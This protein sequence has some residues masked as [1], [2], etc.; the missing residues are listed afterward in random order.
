MLKLIANKGEG[1][2]CIVNKYVDDTTNNEFALKQLK[3]EH[4]KKDDYRYRFNRE[5]SIL[6]ELTG[7]ENIIELVRSGHNVDKERLWYLMPFA[8]LNLY[9]YIKKNNGILMKE[10][11]YN[12]VDQII[13]G[14]KFAHNKNILHRDISPNNVLVF[15]KGES[16]ILK[17]SDFGLG[18]NMDSLSF[19][20]RSSASGY[21]QIL[22]VSPEQRIKL[23]DATDKSDIYSLGKLVYFIFTGKDP[24]N[25]KQFELTS[26][27]SKSIEENPNERF[28]DILEFEKHYL[29]LKEL[30]L[31][32]NI[33]FE[34]LS[35]KDIIDSND[36]IEWVQLH[37]LLVKGLY[38]EH[39]Y[40]EF[41]SPTNTLLLKG[42]NLVDYYRSVGNAI[43]DFVKT[44]SD[45]IDECFG[46]FGWPFSEMDTFGTVFTNII[47]TVNDDETRL[48]CL[49]KLWYLAFVVD[50]WNVQK[51]I[52]EVFN[53]SFIS[54]SIETQL[55]E[56]IIETGTKV[57][58]T[59]FTGI[60]VPK[61]VKSSIIKTNETVTKNEEE[62][63]RRQHIQMENFKW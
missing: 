10:T 14:I 48:I 59:H 3:K 61:I 55:A 53:D 32:N 40:N 43:K 62:E 31:N 35:L 36:K 24:D 2:F 47:K 44:Y 16:L 8:K 41:I 38:F 37:E 5:V 54:T 52:K 46:T 49:K 28:N 21:G 1:Y 17:I 9:E 39:V 51:K 30:Q 27:V 18:K 22:Y 34:H 56:Y 23:K 63:M 29:S 19:Y 6:G 12:F 50:Q 60:T 15:E 26:L 20:T 57:E 58:L 45:R 42:N 4:Y 13:N 11:R 33:D 7:C 25:I